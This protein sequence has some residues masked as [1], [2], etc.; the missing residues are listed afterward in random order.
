M[1]N[2]A[3]LVA[4]FIVA[5]LVTPLSVHSQKQLAKSPKILSAKTV[6]WAKSVERLSR[7]GRIA[8]RR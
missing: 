6:Y 8:N 3:F 7:M 4:V 1:R 2:S 5:C